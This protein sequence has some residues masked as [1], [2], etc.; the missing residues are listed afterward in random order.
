M[1]S[2]IL[3]IVQAEVEPARWEGLM[4]E[5]EHV[6]KND[7]PS[8]VLNAYLVQDNKEKALWR[9]VTIWESLEA[10]TEYRKS[11]ETPIWLQIFQNAGA[12]PELIITEM[13]SSK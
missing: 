4:S 12:K 6:D 7:V 9:I 8:G 1:D 3:T 11:I 5:F 10:I 2:K 13:K